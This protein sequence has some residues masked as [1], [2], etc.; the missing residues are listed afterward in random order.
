MLWLMS[1]RID[2]I[3]ELVP[4]Q[5]LAEIVGVDPSLM[6]RI[7]SGERAPSPRTLAALRDALNSLVSGKYVHPISIDELVE[8]LDVRMAN[9]RY[10][11]EQV[12]A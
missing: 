12:V 9:H 3:V 6:S 4:Q 2:L 5:K 11:E 7:L 8:W 10:E 1:A